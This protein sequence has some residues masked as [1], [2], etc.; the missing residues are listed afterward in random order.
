MQNGG[1]ETNQELKERIEKLIEEKAPKIEGSE[2]NA[3]VIVN[4]C[5]GYNFWMSAD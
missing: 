1:T 3:D 4:V 5:N 2:G